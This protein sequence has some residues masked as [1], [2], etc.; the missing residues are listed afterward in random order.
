MPPVAHFSAD[1]TS[2]SVPLTVQFIDSSRGGRTSWLWDFG[3]DSTSTE[4]N[5]VH[6]YN[7]ADTFTVSLTVAGPN[8]SDTLVRDDY[9]IAM[10]PTG[11]SE[12]SDGLPSKFRLYNNY[13]NP[14]N[15]AT[16]IEFFIPKAE[17]VTLKVYNILGE[18]VATLV[19]E[20]L[21]AGKY[22]NEW[23]ASGLASGVYLYRIQAGSFVDIRKMVLMK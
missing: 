18:E 11:I 15:P 19:S 6:V 3:D 2:G 7:I 14:F 5:P 9:I 16:N 17:F 12:L 22:K 1:T 23:D 4:Q 20:R 10:E 13:P 21:T 8:G